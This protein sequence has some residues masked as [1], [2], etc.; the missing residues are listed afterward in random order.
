MTLPANLDWNLLRL[1][2]A[3]SERAYREATVSDPKTSAQALV[4]SEVINGAPYVI[5]AF[6][7]SKE[8][9]DFIQDAEC[10]QSDLIWSQDDR[11]A[12]VHHGFL[13]DF[14]AIDVAVVKAVKN[15]LELTPTAKVIVTGHSLGG[16]LAILC[17][18][19][20]SRQKL[21]LALVVTFGQ[22]RVGNAAFRD[23]YDASLRD[24]TF[25]VVNQNDLVPRLP[26]VL[27][28]Y[29]HCGQ[30]IFLE[31]GTGWGVNVPLIYKLIADALGL[32][33]AYRNREDV[34]FSQHFIAAY[35]RRMQLI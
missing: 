20:F 21:P 12:S 4:L 24:L 26:G 18:L 2:A 16:A 35:Q 15:V 22:P 30:E 28:S 19:E 5:V 32:W 9:R 25:R 1:L 11:T 7:G 13:E 29:R 17:A 33:G 34:L 31:P 10:W 6:R 3:R 23:I 8:P 27:M 14:E